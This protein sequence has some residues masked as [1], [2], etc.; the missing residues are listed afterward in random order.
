MQQEVRHGRHE[1]T[2]SEL[3]DEDIKVLTVL[4]DDVLESIAWDNYLTVK[5]LLARHCK[6]Y[7]KFEES[8]A[9]EY[10]VWLHKPLYK[11]V[12][13][14]KIDSEDPNDYYIDPKN[15]DAF[16]SMEEVIAY[17]QEAEQVAD[18]VEDKYFHKRYPDLF[19]PPLS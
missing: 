18:E 1:T 2:R 5:K 7:K 9:M 13:L 8:V 14:Y 3:T 10:Y 6:Y 12:C 4:T 15:A 17:H 16:H 19:A 11:S